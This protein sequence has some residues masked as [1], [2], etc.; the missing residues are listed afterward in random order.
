M[1][2]LIIGL[3]GVSG[4][5]KDTVADLIQEV[6]SQGGQGWTKVALADP[7]K[8]IVRDVYDFT[9]EQLWGPSE[10]RNEPDKRYPRPCSDCGGKGDRVYEDTSPG[11]SALQ[12]CMMCHGE[13]VTYLTCREALQ[14]LGTEWARNCYPDTWVDLTIRTAEKLMDPQSRLTY[15]QALGLLQGGVDLEPIWGVLVSDVRYRNELAAIKKAGGMVLRVRRE[16]TLSAEYTSH[17]SEA[18]MGQIQDSEF[19]LVIDNT[20]TLADLETHVRQFVQQFIS[21]GR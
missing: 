20:G 2:N 10:M 19:D 13:K 12:P 4:S 1:K 18:E 15:S 14:Q 21:G 5:G 17:S 7:M 16:T 8:R 6:G 3:S 9:D 11:E